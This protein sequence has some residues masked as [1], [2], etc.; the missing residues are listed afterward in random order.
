MKE[1]LTI[2][3]GNASQLY[4]FGRKSRIALNEAREK[5]AKCIGADPEEV[6]FTSCGTESDNWAIK[7][8]SQNM[9]Q[10]IVSVIEH[11]AVIPISLL[12]YITE[13]NDRLSPSN[14]SRSSMHT[15]PLS[16]TGRYFAFFPLAST[17]LQEFKSG[18][19]MDI[20]MQWI[21]RERLKC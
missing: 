15:S 5:I 16:F 19:L 11:H 3:Y 8:G 6:Y 2:N 7:M 13:T 21:Y 18:E 12:A 17:A 1:Y 20:W 10:I 14:S 9:D 4:D